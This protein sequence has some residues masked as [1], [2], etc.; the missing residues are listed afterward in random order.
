M[1]SKNFSHLK[2]LSLSLSLSLALSLSFNLH[3]YLV[4]LGVGW[5]D[6]NMTYDEIVLISRISIEKKN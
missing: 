1:E 6:L 3:P 5:E 2:S 4:L